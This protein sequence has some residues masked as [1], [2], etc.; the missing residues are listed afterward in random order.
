MHLVYSSPLLGIQNG[1]EERVESS[2]KQ[3]KERRRRAKKIR[4]VKKGAS[5]FVQYRLVF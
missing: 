1:L 5:T 2:R 4:G 3:M